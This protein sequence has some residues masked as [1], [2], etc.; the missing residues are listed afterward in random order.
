MHR[1]PLSSPLPSPTRSVELEWV[2]AKSTPPV[3]RLLTAAAPSTDAGGG[4]GGGDGLHHPPSLWARI[5]PAGR[6]RGHTGSGMDELGHPAPLPSSA[7][8][9][10]SSASL[11]ARRA[12]AA[13]APCLSRL[14]GGSLHRASWFVRL[15][16]A[17][18]LFMAAW[19][20]AEA[21]SLLLLWSEATIFLN[22]LGWVP[23]R[24]RGGGEG[25]RME[26]GE[27]LHGPPP[28]PPC[29]ARRPT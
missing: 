6:T 12:T 3:P 16:L 1:L 14:C 25:G 13:P 21:M 22:L 18:Y 8:G 17:P 15:W 28:P 4:S 29:A 24:R 26:G 2:L 19:A 11:A 10:P 23:V 27:G 20:L 5:L 7:G 9:S